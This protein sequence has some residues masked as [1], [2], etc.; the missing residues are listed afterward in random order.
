M[1][2]KHEKISVALERM[3]FGRYEYVFRCKQCGV[4]LQP[5]YIVRLY[6]RVHKTEAKRK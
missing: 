2:C 6:N 1:K 3:K 5:S 4:E